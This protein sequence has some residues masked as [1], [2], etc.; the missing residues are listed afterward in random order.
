[1]EG[2]SKR[3]GSGVLMVLVFE[4]PGS[5][6]DE[7]LALALSR[8]L[9]LKGVDLGPEP[10]RHWYARRYA[11][12]FWQSKV[13][14]RGA[15]L[16]TFEV[17]ATWDR[18]LPMYDRVVAA[19]GDRALVMAHLSHAYGH[20]CSIYFTFVARAADDEAGLRLYDALWE[21][22]LAAAQAAG[23]AIS[24]HHGIGMSKSAAMGAELGGGLAVLE[25]LKES[26]DPR[27]TMNP[28]KLLPD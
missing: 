18:I 21:D 9:G 4:G 10:A 6:P 20:G 3:I 28:A 25:A 2:S 1:M 16:D 11:V 7:E 12:S 27:G 24:H 8:M 15:F 13:Y 19:L 17:S 23:G 22:G 5:L 14:A 26:F